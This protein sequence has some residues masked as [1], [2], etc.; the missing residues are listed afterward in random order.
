MDWKQSV[1]IVALM[2]ATYGSSAAQAQAVNTVPANVNVLNL[3][4]PFLQLNAT[5]VGRATLQG[6]LDQAVASNNGSS[7]ARRALAISDK[8]LPSNTPFLG[9]ITRVDGSVINLGP[10]DNLAG[11][12]PLQAIQ[13]VAGGAQGTINPIQPVGGYGAVLGANYQTGIRASTA[14][15][16]PLAKTFDLLNRAYT[17]TSSDLGVAKNYFANGAATNP[18]TTPA[19]YVAVPA[20]APAGY[21]LPTFNGL[22]NTTNSVLDLAAGVTNTQPGQDVYGSSRPV[23]AVPNRINVFD[24]T[25]LSGLATN[26]SFPSGH[27]NYGFTDSILLGMLTPSL[28]Q[29]MLARGAEYGDSRIVLGVHYPLDIIAS[30]AFAAYDLA[31]AFTN[32]LYINNA[33]TTGGATTGVGAAINLPSLFTQARAELSG[34]LSAQCGAAVATC[35]TSAANTTNDPYV[36]SA[37]NQTLYQ[38]RLTYN[39]PILTFAQA[40]REAAAAGGPDASILLATVYGGST[41]AAATLAPNGGLYGSLQ[42]GTIN[43]ILVNTETN[44]LAAFYG[45]ALSYWSRIDLYSAA[46]YFQNVIGTLRLDATDRVT[47]DVTIGNSGAL[48]ANGTITGLVTVGSGGLLGG[49]GTVGGVSAL[50]GGTVAPGNSIGTLNVSGNVA[51]A[52]GS[53]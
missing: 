47:T 25:A 17:F 15:T 32:P 41:T 18:S 19:D 44:A 24:P 16:G 11:G 31:Q 48:Y 21:T 6:N 35:A 4:S 39:L 46:G 12:L 14:T 9:S 7:P 52:S 38:Q 51:F 50:T 40:P 13:S 45:T 22:P 34:Y 23:Q 43:Q 3:L 5:A 29:S 49:S 20:V 42:T 33:A 26:P 8:A 27:T 1:S 30:R 2:A 28:Y 37:A 10:A 36:P 53:T